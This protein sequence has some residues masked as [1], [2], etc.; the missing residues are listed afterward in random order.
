MTG[1]TPAH[2]LVL[3]RPSTVL[4]TWRAPV[5]SAAAVPPSC[6]DARGAA[7]ATPARPTTTC[8]ADDVARL[9]DE[10]AARP[11]DPPG[12]PGGRHRRQHGEPGP[13][14]RQPAD[15]HLRHRAGPALRTPRRS[16]SAR[17]ARTRST[18]VPFSEDSLWQGYPE[19]TNAPYGIAKMA[20]LVQAQAYR[21]QYGFRTSLP[22][23]DEPVRPGRQLQPRVEP[24][25]PR[26][27]PQVRGGAGARPHRG[28]GHRRG[29]RE[30]L[31]VDDAA[32]AIVLAPE[33]T[34]APSR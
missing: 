8:A 3:G 15:G 33:P 4:V 9:F 34:T 5:S 16:S 12:R 11:R 19:E 26:A 22:D 20:Q 1:T 10:R 28:V 7:S 23:A 14:P 24:R 32:E 2:E 13:L 21:A 29:V 25:H 6:T 30:F 31:Y 18:P 17:S 27:D